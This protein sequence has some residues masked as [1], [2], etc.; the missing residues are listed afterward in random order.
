MRLSHLNQTPEAGAAAGT[1]VEE[2]TVKVA[3]ADEK[4]TSAPSRPHAAKEI[5]A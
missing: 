4:Q 3:H 5:V 2:V 1:A